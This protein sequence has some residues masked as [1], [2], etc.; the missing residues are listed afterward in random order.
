MLLTIISTWP[1]AVADILL[2][3]DKKQSLAAM[4]VFL[5]FYYNLI[6]SGYTI[7]A[8][9]AKLILLAAIFLYIHANLPERMYIFFFTA[10]SMF[11]FFPLPIC[12]SLPP[13]P[14][15]MIKK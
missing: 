2:W 8:S 3:K 5:A 11:P 14:T 9:I 15:S 12:L 7:V 13:P 10:C 6:A 4:L 1:L